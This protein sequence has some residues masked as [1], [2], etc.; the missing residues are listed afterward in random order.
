MIVNVDSADIRIFSDVY[1]NVTGCILLHLTI[2]YMQI[3][4]SMDAP[5]FAKDFYISNKLT[6]SIQKRIKGPKDQELQI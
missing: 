3:F 4:L 5:H 6:W 1:F 2:N